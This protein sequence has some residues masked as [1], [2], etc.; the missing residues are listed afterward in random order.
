MQL[1]FPFGPVPRAAK[2]PVTKPATV[3]DVGLTVAEA[4]NRGAK[5]DFPKNVNAVRVTIGGKTT[6][7]LKADADTLK[8]AG[9]AT[10]VEF[11]TVKNDAKGHPVRKGFAALKAVTDG[12]LVGGALVLSLQ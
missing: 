1:S 11:G 10:A 6:V 3:R 4:L 8:G 5:V 2:A 7:I 9:V 12:N